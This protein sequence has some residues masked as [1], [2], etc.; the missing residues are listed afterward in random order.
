L[1]TYNNSCAF[2][3]LPDWDA[4]F[5]NKNV[6][7][8]IHEMEELNLK[9]I[10]ILG[11]QPFSE[12]P[13][14]FRVFPNLLSNFSIQTLKFL[15][16]VLVRRPQLFFSYKGYW[17]NIF[18]PTFKRI[19][20]S[21]YVIKADSVFIGDLTRIKN[22]LKNYYLKSAD[23]VIVESEEFAQEY[24]KYVATKIVHT[25][26]NQFV[27]PSESIEVPFDKYIFFPGRLSYLKGVDVA[28]RIFSKISIIYPDVKLVFMGTDQNDGVIR[29]I[30]KAN[31]IK[32]LPVHFL[33]AATDRLELVSFYRSAIVTIITSRDEGLPNRLCE[34]IAC[35]SPVLS[36]DIGN[37]KALDSY[38]SL[39][40]ATSE[41]DF[42]FKMDLLLKDWEYYQMLK[43]AAIEE[44]RDFR[45]TRSL[46][47]AILNDS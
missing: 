39:V 46:L 1:N 36:I 18:F 11:K 7:T 8:F 43:N 25:Y 9:V 40:I 23:A 3:L 41:E 34:A 24:R 12:P 16:F 35:E 44:S 33:D 29:E 5:L 30:I 28:Y 20:G 14:E 17:V 19:Y 22:R 37:V 15:T 42:V 45:K 13:F 26:H 27:V 6:G 31:K 10:L 32:S 21:Q 2:Y 4:T 38:K 47:G